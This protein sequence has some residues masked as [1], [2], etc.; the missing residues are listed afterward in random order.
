VWRASTS[1]RGLE[2]HDDARF[3]RAALTSV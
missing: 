1:R 2:E 3:V